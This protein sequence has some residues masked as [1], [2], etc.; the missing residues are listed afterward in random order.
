[1]EAEKRRRRIKSNREKG[2]CKVKA[3]E[4]PDRL[5]TYFGEAKVM[6]IQQMK[7]DCG[8]RV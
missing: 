3:D 7:K 2:D 5:M 6:I 1:M 4:A 8:I